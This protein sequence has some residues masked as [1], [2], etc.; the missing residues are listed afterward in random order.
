MRSVK[1]S[2]RLPCAQEWALC[3]RLAIEMEPQSLLLQ[4]FPFQIGRRS[5][6]SLTLPR[7]TISGLHAELFEKDQRLFVRDMGSKNGT[8]VNGQRLTDEC[9]LQNNDLVQFAD[10]PFRVTFNQADVPS[11]TRCKDACD[12]ALAIVQFEGLLSGTSLSAHFQPIVKLKTGGLFAFESL[13]RSRLI[14]LETPE[15]MFNAAAQLGATMKLSREMRRVSVEACEHF[16][17]LPHIFLNTHP[18]ELSDETL[19]ESCR[20]LRSMAPQQKITIEIH[21]AAVSNIDELKAL[22]RG[23]DEIDIKL[24]FDDFGSGQAR[25]TELAVIR[26]SCIKFD[27]SMIREINASD[28]SRRRV[29][30][31]LVSMM[32]ELEITPLAEGVETAEEHEACLDL[33]FELAQGYFY[34]KPMPT[35]HYCNVHPA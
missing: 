13:A 5:G 7:Q 15:F 31:C 4:S 1:M 33:G 8:F 11:E 2:G 19:L 10:A 32:H 12:E 14:G 25:L 21:E 30:A 6:L 35:A 26:P 27:R 9:E 22:A 20:E 34:G 16:S 18:S 3:G 23:L 17:E 24:A 29:V 28:A